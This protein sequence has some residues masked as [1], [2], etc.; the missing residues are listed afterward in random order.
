MAKA[1]H[2]K[3]AGWRRGQRK[4]SAVPEDEKKSKFIV[5]HPRRDFCGCLGGNSV[6][7]FHIFGGL[8]V[9]SYVG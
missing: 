9:P 3:P 1:F 6:C 7:G 8:H 2:Q 4:T 5:V